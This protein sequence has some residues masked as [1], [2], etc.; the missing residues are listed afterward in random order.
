MDLVAGPQGSGKS[1][2]FPVADRPFNSFNI[3]DHRRKLN[4]GF[5]QNIPPEIRT[6]ATKD[7]EAFVRT[8]IECKSSFSIEVTLANEATFEQADK[9]QGEGFQIHLT[10]VAA[11]VE[12][13]IER[14]VTRVIGGG[15]GISP[16][17]IQQTYAKSMQNL[18]RAISKFD[19]VL[20]YDN[21]HQAGLD[22]DQAVVKPRLVLKSEG[23]RISFVDLTP[24]LWLK[25]AL[26][27]TDY[28]LK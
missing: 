26:S 20:V 12:D 21:S 1:T 25:N 24:P 6:R 7:Y 16:E 2:F 18:S 4:Q 8:Q 10:F 14:V 13:S 23:G 17:V 9:A 22:D 3:D 19:V 27:D 5:S 15:H 11:A 28:E